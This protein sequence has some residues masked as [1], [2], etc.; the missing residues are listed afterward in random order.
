MS[1]LWTRATSRSEEWDAAAL[2]YDRYRPRYP[3]VL[4]DDVMELAN[5]VPG[6]RVVEIG[7]GTGI[8][9]VPLLNRGYQVTAIEPSG[10]MAAV[11]ESKMEGRARV[12]VGTF[13][14]APLEPGVDLVVAFNSWHWVNPAVGVPRL[15]TLLTPGG[16]VALVW[17][18][19]ISWGQDPFEQLVADQL[20]FSW[21]HH[22]DQLVASKE[23]LQ[24]DGCFGP[25][26]ERR[27]RFERHLDAETYLAVMRTYGGTHTAERDE[28]VREVINGACGGAVTKTED[29]VVYVSHR[30]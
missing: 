18:E 3:A 9:T 2:A 30:R 19:V 17:T 28:V 26:L 11:A 6:S 15:A 4:F 25:F 1:E 29:A 22:Y 13:E 16:T 5:L 8:A 21:S 24:Q 12:V 14:D 7:A 23:S 27:Y 20:G 10:G